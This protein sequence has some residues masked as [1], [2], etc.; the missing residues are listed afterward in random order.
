MAGGM[1]DRSF[2][3]WRRQIAGCRID[4]SSHIFVP[5]KAFVV[6]SLRDTLVTPDSVSHRSHRHEA[7]PSSLDPGRREAYHRTTFLAEC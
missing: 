6:S 7:P 4:M 3:R 1:F 2:K 5:R